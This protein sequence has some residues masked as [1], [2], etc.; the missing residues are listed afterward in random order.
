MAT[1]PQRGE[2][3]LVSLGSAPRG[4]QGKNW[5]VIVISVDEISTGLDEELI[6]VVPL[7]TTRAPSLLRP[8]VSLN[9]GIAQDS[10]ALCRGVRS[11]ERRRLYRSIGEIDDDTLR[12]VEHALSMILGID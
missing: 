5:P 6:V 4:E 2:I 9:A 10:V 8:K 7:S 12:E 11:V 3:W 1:D